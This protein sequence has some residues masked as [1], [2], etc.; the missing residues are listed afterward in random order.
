MS[1]LK[2]AYGQAGTGTLYWC[3]YGDEIFRFLF[4][5]F[6]NWRERTKEP[7]I[8]LRQTA[9]TISYFGSLCIASPVKEMRRR[10]GL[11]RRTRPRRLK[12]KLTLKFQICPSHVVKVR[13]VV[14][15]Y[16]IRTLLNHKTGLNQL[17]GGIVW[18]CPLPYMSKRISIPCTGEW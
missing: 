15:T 1:A 5:N 13:R 10:G 17:M 7:L 14:A 18:A 3:G 12:P 6:W 8:T 4:A 16:D 9:S 2:A 11:W